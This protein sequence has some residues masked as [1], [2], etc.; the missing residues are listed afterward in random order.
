MDEFTNSLNVGRFESVNGL[1]N[2]LRLNDPWS[3]GYTTTL[4]ETQEFPDKESWESFYYSSGEARAIEV[5]KLSQQV[6]DK[7]NN[8]QLVLTNEH[9]IAQMRWNLK[10][11]NLHFG[12]TKE[13]I[14]AKGKILFE[15]ALK[16]RIDITEAECV[17]AVRYRTICQTWNGVVIRER[18]AIQLLKQAFT[19][20]MFVKTPGEFDYEYAVDF[21]L[22]N[23]EKLLC[24]IQVKP[25]SYQKSNASYVLNAKAANKR[26]NEKYHKRYGVPV[27]DVIYEK[28][29]I[30]NLQVLEQI[31]KLV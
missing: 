29:Q 20:L 26:K 11:L 9:E 7:L 31:K 22:Y 6:Q 4:V 14:R 28:G 15:A 30:T 13:Q 21:Q 8:E 23:A 5:S 19:A 12:R 24:G 10:T 27:I 16:K 3:V 17:E 2:D 25:A 1:W 18:K